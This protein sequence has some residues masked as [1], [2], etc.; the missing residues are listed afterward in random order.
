MCN[1]GNYTP[2]PEFEPFKVEGDRG[3]SDNPKT[4]VPGPDA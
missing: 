2:K 4:K 1:G 3:N